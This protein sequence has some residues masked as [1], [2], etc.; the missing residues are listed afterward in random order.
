MQTYV[1]GLGISPAH[2]ALRTQRT[3]ELAFQTVRAALADA[4]VNRQAVDTVTLATS[5]EMDGRAISSM[6]MAAPSG[7][8]LKD[9]IRVTDA[10]LSGL[11]LGALRIA[12][13]CSSIG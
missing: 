12:T 11:M 4:G 10:G 13:G 5:D 1:M 6:L 8:Y 9:E 2:E 7:A 3:E